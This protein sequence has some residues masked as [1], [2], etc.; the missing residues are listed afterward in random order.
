MLLE[1]D[2]SFR[3]RLLLVVRLED[4]AVTEVASG[5]ILDSIG[6]S[7]GK[8]RYGTGE[9]IELLPTDNLVKDFKFLT[10][11]IRRRIYAAFGYQQ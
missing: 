8:H 10:E 5:E 1:P 9:V 6:A 4:R 11:E 2:S 7:Y 3:E